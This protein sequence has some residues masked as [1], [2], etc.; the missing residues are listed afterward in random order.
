MPTFFLQGKYIGQAEADLQL[1]L[2]VMSK[3][4]S[5]LKLFFLVG[6]QGQ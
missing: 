4:D 2:V 3:Y 1:I 6:A 5:R